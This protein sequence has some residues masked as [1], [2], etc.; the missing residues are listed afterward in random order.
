MLPTPE[1]AEATAKLI[2]WLASPKALNLEIPRAWIGVADGSVR[3]GQV[4]GGEQRRPGIYA[5]H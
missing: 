5:H 1:Q 2:G 4:D 3:M